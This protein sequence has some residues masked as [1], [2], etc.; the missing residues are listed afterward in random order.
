M[1]ARPRVVTF[2]VVQ[3]PPGKSARAWGKQFR[4]RCGFDYDNA[5]RVPTE[6]L[7]WPSEIPAEVL[8]QNLRA[9]GVTFRTFRGAP[10]QMFHVR[11]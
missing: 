1:A 5:P 11:G 4:D 3:V 2:F 10:E 9:A 6:L 8:R 7:V